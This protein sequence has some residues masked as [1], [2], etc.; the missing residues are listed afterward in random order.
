MTSLYHL[1]EHKKHSQHSCVY[2]MS[3]FPVYHVCSFSPRWRLWGN[4]PEQQLSPGPSRRPTPVSCCWGRHA[5]QFF[6]YGRDLRTRAPEGPSPRGHL[7]R[8]QAQGH[9]CCLSRHVL[10]FGGHHSRQNPPLVG[11]KRWQ[12]LVWKYLRLNLLPNCVRCLTHGYSPVFPPPSCR[13]LLPQR[14]SGSSLP[15]KGKSAIFWSCKILRDLEESNG[16]YCISRLHRCLELF[17]LTMGHE[18][19]R[20]G[21]LPIKVHTQTCN[22]IQLHIYYGI[23]N[24]KI[25]V[26]Y[27]PHVFEWIWMTF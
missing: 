4:S 21:G 13:L 18:A 10:Q 12:S 27:Y 19:P 24:I 16:I 22:R 6:S 7:S 14:V 23:Q 20:T 9:F 3:Q 8:T 2:W 11:D 26:L 17:W 1:T 15:D 25:N 5:G